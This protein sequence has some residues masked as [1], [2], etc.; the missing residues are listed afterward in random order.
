LIWYEEITNESQAIE[1]AIEDKVDIIN[2]SWSFNKSSAALEGAINK[3]VAEEPEALI[4]CAKSDELYADDVFPADYCNTISVAAATSR[5]RIGTEGSKQPDLLILGENMPA[6]G[7]DY[8]TKQEKEVKISGSSVATALASGM[9][10]LILMV[11]KGDVIM[12][13]NWKVLKRRGA[14]LAL[15]RRFKTDES[16]KI[17]YVNPAM[18]FGQPE[19]LVAEMRSIVS[20]ENGSQ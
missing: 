2:L 14:M 12:K 3:A 19:R 7:P 4:F 11:A 1:A 13:E 20:S 8:A 16:S 6:D 10:S 18:I 9:A 5:G 17:T 15:F